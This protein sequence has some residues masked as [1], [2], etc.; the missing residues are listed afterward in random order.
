MRSA[1]SRVRTA[2]GV[3]GWIEHANL[4]DQATYDGLQS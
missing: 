4:V 1:F 3:E 2:S